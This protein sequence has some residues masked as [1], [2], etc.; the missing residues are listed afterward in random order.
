MQNPKNFI[1]LN[2]IFYK[3]KRERSLSTSPSPKQNK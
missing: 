3:T 2:K 1:V